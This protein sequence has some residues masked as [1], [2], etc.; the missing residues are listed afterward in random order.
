[1]HGNDD[2]MD[3]DGPEFI[4]MIN[5][6]V[7]TVRSKSQPYQPASHLPDRKYIPFWD[8]V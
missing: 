6:M 2:Y 8:R 5:D 7:R 3:E 1:M 4:A